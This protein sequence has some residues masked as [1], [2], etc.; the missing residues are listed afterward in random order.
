MDID[1]EAILEAAPVAPAFFDHFEDITVDGPD[2]PI[3]ARVGGSG[4]PVVLLHGYPQTS[5]M[6]H[7]IAPVLAESHRVIC[8]DL[9]GYGRSAK[10]PTDKAHTPYTKR[11]MAA[12]ILT[13][14][15][16]LGHDRFLLGAHDRGARVAHRLAA[17]HPDRVR[18]LTTLD[19]APTREMYAVGDARFA[20]AYWHW[21]WLIQA[22]PLPE[23]LIGADPDWYWCR[24]C[25]SGKAG[26]RPFVRQAL[27]E[28]LAAFRDPRTIHSSCEDYR[29]AWTTDII[30]D[31]AETRKLPMPLLALW[32]RDGAI[33]AHFDCLDLWRRRAEDVRGRALPGGHYL[34]EE[35]PEAVLAEWLPFF[36]IAPA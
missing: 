16:T 22:A 33:E 4:P 18:A 12:D 24:K 35:V 13:F 36:K 20:A 30:H 6:W 2:G 21:Y 26:A 8:P 15:D 9:R 34:A 27:E 14:M 25:C 11:A 10:P 23:R 7:R 31:D 3:F 5:A 28:Y 17:D 19:I 1:P 32:G 29:A